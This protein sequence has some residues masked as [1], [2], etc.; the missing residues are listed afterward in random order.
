MNDWEEKAK[1]DPDIDVVAL[2]NFS[3]I[4]YES[5]KTTID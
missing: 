1:S 3:S 4:D 5:G 2:F